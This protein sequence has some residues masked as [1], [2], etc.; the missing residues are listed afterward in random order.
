VKFAFKVPSVI[1]DPLSSRRYRDRKWHV[2]LVHKDGVV[3]YVG[4]TSNPLRRL[5]QHF[6]YQPTCG[7]EG[8]VEWMNNGTISCVISW[9]MSQREAYRLEAKVIRFAKPLFNRAYNA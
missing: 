6:Y 7:K 9:P 5:R 3:G 8:F 2:Y 4:K 1:G